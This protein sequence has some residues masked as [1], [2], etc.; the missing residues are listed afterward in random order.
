MTR[1]PASTRA[2]V[3][4][5]FGGPEV[6]AVVDVPIPAPGNGQVLLDVRAAAV[7]PADVKFYTGVF[8]TDPGSL[9]MRLGFE[10]SGVVTAVGPGVSTASVGDEVVAQPLNGGNAERVVVAAENVFPKPS[11]LT[12]EEASG[13]LVVGVTAVHLVTASRAGAGETV[14][15]HGAGG[16]VGL[17]ALQLLVAKGARVIGTASPR[18]HDDL[19]ALGA[20]PVAYGEGLADR[21]RSLAPEGVDVALDTVGTDEAV[22]VSLELVA[23]RSRIVTVA[24]FGRAPGLGIQ[25]LGTG[26]GADPGEDIRAAARSELLDLAGQGRLQV[27]VDRTYPLDE[28]RAAH[29]YV[30]SGHAAGK[31]VLIP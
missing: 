9:P 19:R 26:E 24:A 8:G 12:F 20:E 22:D 21:V 2:V 6:L 28:V 7:N 18:R 13:L 1:N 25:L 16:G 23:D 10:V 30:M 4:T 27:V 31:V 11:R 3:A 17:V 5:A 29:E 15:L 14:L